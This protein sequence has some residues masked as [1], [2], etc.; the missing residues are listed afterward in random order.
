MP[1]WSARLASTPDSRVF[2]FY[3]VEHGG[4]AEHPA[5][6]DLLWKLMRNEAVSTGPHFAPEAPASLMLS[7][8][9]AEELR[10]APDPNARFAA[11]PKDVQRKLLQIA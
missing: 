3:G 5:M 8:A 6:L 1:W 7:N 10:S 9:V 4:A 11:L 2:D